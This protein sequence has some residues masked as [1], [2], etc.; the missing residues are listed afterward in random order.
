VH[1][2]ADHF[3][4]GPDDW[5]VSIGGYS[6]RMDPLMRAPKGSALTSSGDGDDGPPGDSGSK[7]GPPMSALGMG[8]ARI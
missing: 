6:P 7:S 5:E 3:A 1:P 4:D 2:I 8:K